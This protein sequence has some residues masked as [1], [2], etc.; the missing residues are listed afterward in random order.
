[1]PSGGEPRKRIKAL[2][3]GRG[4]K[5]TDACDAGAA[6]DCQGLGAAWREPAGFRLP[7][8]GPTPSRRE[9]ADGHGRSGSRTAYPGSGVS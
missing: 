4:S 7:R 6:E 9:K 8:E 2:L 3:S 5:A 1:M